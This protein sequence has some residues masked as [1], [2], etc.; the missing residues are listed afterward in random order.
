MPHPHTITENRW[1]SWLG[2]RIKEPNLWHLNRRSVSSGVA[3][4]I[5]CAFIPGPIQIF[6]AVFLCFMVRGNLP[7]ALGSTWISNPLTYIPIYYFC[8]EV[9]VWILGVPTDSM[10]NPIKIHIQGN[11]DDFQRLADQ[12]L[13]VGWEAIGT[14]LLGCFVVGVICSA[15]SFVFIRMLWRLHV[16]RAITRRKERL[17]RRKKH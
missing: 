6:M 16:Y 14:L 9:G 12:L 7:L 13:E 8:Y 11:V 4:G 5:L 10:G 3:I 17:L 2:P 15:S 1:L